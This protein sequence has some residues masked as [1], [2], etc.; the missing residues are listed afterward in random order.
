MTTLP[1]KRFRIFVYGT[2]KCGG[3]YYR[4][5][6]EG[7]AC[8]S[9]PAIARGRLY[10]LPAGYP[11]LTRGDDWVRGELLCFDDRTLLAALDHLEGFNPDEVS[12]ENEYT[13]E[14]CEVFDM[15]KQPL[16]RFETY[17]MS[18]Y[19]VAASGGVYMPD[20]EWPLTT[21]G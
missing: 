4:Q 16:G 8:E 19:R 15:E 13:R 2:L 1:Q 14:P 6:C 3:F 9:V 12:S 17:L 5:F 18:P 11:A 7:H 20:G 10:A 21:E